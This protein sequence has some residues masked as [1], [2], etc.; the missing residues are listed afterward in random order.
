MILGGGAGRAFAR[1]EVR[2]ILDDADDGP[3][4]LLV[5]TDRAWIHAVDVA[6]GGTGADAGGEVCHRTRQRIEQRL[7]PLDEMEHGAPGGAWPEAGQ[8]RQKLDQAV[9]F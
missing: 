4:A 7:T 9:D 6:A 1:P 5:A 2:H 3:I 8:P